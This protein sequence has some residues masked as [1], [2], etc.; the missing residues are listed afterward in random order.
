MAQM[1]KGRLESAGIEA[2][3]WGENIAGELPLGESGI[4]GFGA[5]KVV[6]PEEELEKA[7]AVLAP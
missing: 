3:L 6:V 7:K 5:V 4:L 2:Y 1:V